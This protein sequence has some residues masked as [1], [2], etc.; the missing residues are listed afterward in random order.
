MQGLAPPIMRGAL[1]LLALRA[2]AAWTRRRTRDTP[3]PQ[4]E[5]LTSDD[6]AAASAAGDVAGLSARLKDHFARTARQLGPTEDKL[7]LREAL[8]AKGAGS[9]Y[10]SAYKLEHDLEQLEC[11]PARN[12]S[13]RRRGWDVDIPWRRLA[14]TPRLGRGHSVETGSRRRRGWDVDIPWRRVAATPR[15]GRG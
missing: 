4:T 15:L 3:P 9:H 5:P 2:D 8:V 13:R 6:V 11:F 14:A 12:G 10:S 7:P 1:L